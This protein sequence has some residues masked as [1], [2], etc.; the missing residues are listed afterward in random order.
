MT[1]DTKDPQSDL[2][3]LQA[4]LLT[5]PM[6]TVIGTRLDV[7][8]ISDAIRALREFCQHPDASLEDVADKWQTLAEVLG[9]NL[10]ACLVRFPERWMWMAYGDATSGK[11][12]AIHDDY[13]AVWINDAGFVAC[14]ARRA[15]GGVDVRFE[16]KYR[17]A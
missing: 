13:T 1:R 14:Y 12:H 4:L 11:R 17:K 7:S 10:M 6:V 9:H 8:L 5:E 16:C 15:S 2:G 3:I